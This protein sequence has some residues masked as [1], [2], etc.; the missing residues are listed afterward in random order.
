MANGVENKVFPGA[1]VGLYHNRQEENTFIG[2]Y[3]TTR[4]DEKGEVVVPETLFDLAS[5][6][7]P[8]CTV[9]GMLC[10]LQGGKIRLESRL[11]DVG[12]YNL[13]TEFN[14]I[15]VRHLLC[16]SSGLPAYKPYYASFAPVINKKN[17]PGILKAILDEQLAYR[18]GSKCVYSDLGFILLGDVI[19]TAAGQPLD[20]FFQRRIIGPLGLEKQILFRPVSSSAGKGVKNIAATE[21]CLWRGRMIQG[22]VHDEHSWLMN[23]V[24]GHAGLFGTIGGVLSLVVHL[25][26]QWRGEGCHP[27]FSGSLLRQALTR[28]YAGQTWC[29]GFDTPSS[30]HSSAGKYF[31]S[32]ST[33]HLGYT[34]TSFWMD[35]DREL[36]VVLLSNR[37]HPTRTN[38]RIKRFRPRFHDAVV[39]AV[40]GK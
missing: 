19:E 12:N 9:L 7:K 21:Q 28:Q 25:L 40:E 4:N 27:E 3:G 37:V 34:G 11:A 16:H 6:T 35:P 30:D 18:P 13:R 26:K 23:G 31:S 8:L 20:I 14:D 15:T 36:A 2:V 39:E 5:L 24:A 33:G 22:E 17:K 38:E 10:L 29:L 32:R 1:A